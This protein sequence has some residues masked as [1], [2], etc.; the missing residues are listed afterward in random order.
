MSRGEW[1]LQRTPYE[2][3]QTVST[4]GL[5]LTF[6]VLPGAGQQL[7]EDVEGALVFGLA[8]SSGF[9]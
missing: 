1:E 4:T 7:V 6:E 5:G 3:R 2:G 9:F 8:D